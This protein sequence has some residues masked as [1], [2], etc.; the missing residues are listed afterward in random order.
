[1]DVSDDPDKY[2]GKNLS[3]WVT[4]EETRRFREHYLQP[5]GRDDRYVRLQSGFRLICP[6]CILMTSSAEMHQTD[7][8]CDGL[9][10]RTAA[11]LNDDVV[12]LMLLAVQRRNLELSVKT[13]LNR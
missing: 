4:L 9:I 12:A 5:L 6:G 7:S 13:A 11:E 2:P 10:E 8:R 3:E 1:M